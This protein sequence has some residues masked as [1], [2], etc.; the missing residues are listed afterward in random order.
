MAEDLQVQ[1]SAPLKIPSLQCLLALCLNVFCHGE[2]SALQKRAPG[3]DSLSKQL[4]ILCQSPIVS[5]ALVPQVLVLTTQDQVSPFLS[6]RSLVRSVHSR[7][8]GTLYSLS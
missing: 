3:W 1:H 6:Q 5:L 2:R 8:C 4:A 7:F